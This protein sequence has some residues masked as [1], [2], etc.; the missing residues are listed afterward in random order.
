MS[1][2]PECPWDTRPQSA[3]TGDVAA[4]LDHYADM[5][6][7]V[8]EALKKRLQVHR[9]D[10]LVRVDRQGIHGAQRY[11]PE[12]RDMHFAKTL[13]AK[14]TL[15]QWTEQQ[16]ALGLVYCEANY[17]VMVPTEGRNVARVT[18]PLPANLAEALNEMAQHPPGAG[19]ATDTYA[20]GRIL[21][22]ARAGLSEKE[23]AKTLGQHG[24][25]GRRLGK[26]DLF[27]V[28][29]PA[30]ASETAVAALLAKHPQLK[31]AE[32][33]QRIAPALV[34]NDPYLG[35]QWHLNKIGATSA[36]DSSQGNGTTIAILD[37]GVDGT[38]PDLSARMVAGWNFYDNN[39]DASDVLGHGTAVAG[40]AAASSNNAV[41]VAGVAGQA[42]IMPLRITDPSGYAY[43]ST[44]A[45]GLT[46]A[47]D[48]GAKVANISF[49]GVAGS[50]A[51]QNAAQYMKNKGG[52]VVVAAGNNGIDENLTP[53]TTMI[54]VSA[55]D[56]NDLRT[57]WSSYGSF[58]A[59]SAPGQ[60]IWTTTKGGGYQAWWGTSLASPV[61]AGVVAQML[62]AKPT[63][64]NIQQESLLYASATD[65]GTAGR[66]PYYGYGRV[67]AAAAVQASLAASPPAD[68]QAPIAAIAAPAGGATVSAWVAVNV[69]ASDNVGVA[70]VELRVNGSTVATDNSAPYGFSWDSTTVPNGMVNLVAQAFDAAGN[71]ASSATITVNVA[72]GAGIVADVTPPVLTLSNPVNGA[73]LS[74]NT[75]TVTVNATDNSGAAGI[76]QT[77]FIDGAQVA[78][79]SGG[80]LSYSWNIR[81]AAVGSHTIKAVAKDAAGNTA[82]QSISVSK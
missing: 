49:N 39:A 69:N 59:I 35:S 1:S 22:M 20:K 14:V 70:R 28:D 36:W 75:V 34:T 18:R 2:L 57:S 67:N 63:L 79:G 8:R 60:D 47:A 12:L 80:S 54:P 27:V 76:A 33:D 55:T 23:L 10:E 37:T 21:V 78:S 31:F 25:K 82:T 65:L 11:G 68:T 48:Q 52:L 74:G 9:F 45:Q 81:K 38:H 5:P 64:S 32:L 62:S 72:N 7:P 56:Q 26:S 43:W 4:A 66:D 24:G 6:A 41:G 30:Q 19:T 29:L 77:L 3:Y 73:K 17:C 58:V 71:S 40:A 53:T 13:C 44:V 15:A 46:W 42:R 50:L 51:V 16:L 61:V